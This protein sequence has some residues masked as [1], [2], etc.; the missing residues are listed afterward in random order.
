M[1]DSTPTAAALV[2]AA[3]ELF[4]RHGYDGASV[5]AITA[6]AGANLGA[7]TY[8]FGTKE[9]LYEAVIGAAIGPSYERLA[10]AAETPG[11]PLDRV[12]RLVRVFF[13]FLYEN[14]DLPTLMLQQLTSSRPMPEVALRTMQANVRV[15]AALITEG[16]QDG[17]VRP[18]D[19]QLMAL[20][21]GSQPIWLTLAR[22][23]LQAS[24]AIDQDD[25]ETRAQLVESVVRFVRAG[26]ATH[27]ENL[28]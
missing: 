27:P 25:P 6:R 14:P 23:A 10:S 22:P 3:C 4:A 19:A 8:H 13:D 18:G 24:V 1:N 2:R 7:I 28:R 16:Q 12:E 5:R 17:S 21:I 26:L 15:I 9:A 11:P 20:S